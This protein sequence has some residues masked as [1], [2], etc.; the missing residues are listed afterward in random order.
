MNAIARSGRMGREILLV[1]AVVACCARADTIKLKDG[2]TLEGMILSE[3]DQRITIE[4][5]YAGGTITKRETVQRAEV[6][7]VIRLTAEQKAYRQTQK[8]RLDPNNSYPQP[9]Y[10]DQVITN[11]FRPFLAQYPQSSNA[12][13]ISDKILQ[14][15]T[16][17]DQVVAGQVKYHGQWMSAEEARPLIVE[18]R[19]GQS[20]EQ[21][22]TL[23]SQSIFERAIQLIESAAATTHDPQ[24]A[25]EASQL[26]AS[27]YRQWLD[28]LHRQQQQINADIQT[29]QQRAASARDTQS[30]AESQAR[31]LKSQIR[32]NAYR[33]LGQG[34]SA[35]QAEAEAKRAQS[36]V[37]GSEN[38]VTQLQQQL[39]TVNQRIADVQAR[40]ASASASAGG[41]APTTVAKAQQPGTSE[42]PYLPPSVP[43]EREAPSWPRFGQRKPDILPSDVEPSVQSVR[44]PSATGTS[45]APWNVIAT[46]FSG[47]LNLLMGI[48]L[49]SAMIGGIWLLVVAFQESVLWGIGTIFIP[50]VGLIFAVTHWAE[51]KWPFLVNLVGWM[52]L[53]A[54]VFTL[55]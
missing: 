8:Y 47:R 12:A 42:Q 44:P 29:Y 49:L 20:L 28:S 17:R 48:G 45:L 22:R 25:A 31:T 18:D 40:A 15:Q 21:A 53:Y 32:D 13:E 39:A 1:T 5:Q 36:A 10:Y 19:A 11:V 9:A 33:G 6:A 30:Q 46:A 35:D 27:A 38:Q 34:S 7:E 14:W 24:H 54:G 52:L 16:E 51:A 2:T 23:L 43:L 55:K 37:T 26:R 41:S 50:L 3:D 4:I